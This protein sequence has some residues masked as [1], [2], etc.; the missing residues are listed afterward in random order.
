MLQVHGRADETIGYG[1]GEINGER[2][3][4]AAGTVG[5]WRQADGCTGRRSSGASFDADASSSGKDL[6]QTTWTGCRDDTEV[7][8]WTIAD[9]AGHVP[10]LTRPSAELFDGW[11]PTTRRA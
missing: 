3:T 5:R 2:Y 8:L 6:T 10:A 1:G 7:T 4:S 11:R 9:T